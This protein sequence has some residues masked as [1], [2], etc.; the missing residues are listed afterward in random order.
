ML[1]LDIYGCT[2][3][4]QDK[5]AFNTVSLWILEYLT[6]HS[7]QLPFTFTQGYFLGTNLQYPWQGP[8][9]GVAKSS[10]Y[11]VIYNQRQPVSILAT[12]SLSVLKNF[13]GQRLHNLIDVSLSYVSELLSKQTCKLSMLCSSNSSFCPDLESLVTVASLVTLDPNI[14]NSTP[15]ILSTSLNFW[16]W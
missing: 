16:L 2:H 10:H 9:G 15:A 6:F 1:I 7:H 14:C 12:E 11:S 5:T 3:H 8:F 4:N 13:L